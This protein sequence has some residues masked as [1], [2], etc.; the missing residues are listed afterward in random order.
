MWLY[1]YMYA[2]LYIYMHVSAFD[3]YYGCYYFDYIA[4]HLF[5]FIHIYLFMY[6]FNR[7]YEA[8]AVCSM[9]LDQKQQN[10]PVGFQTLAG[11]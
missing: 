1:V 4:Y 9:M 10:S 7:K 2:C 11:A 8:F 5:I 6:L 3:D